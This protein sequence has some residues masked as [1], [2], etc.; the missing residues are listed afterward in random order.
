M[1][2]CPKCKR[3][4]RTLPDEEQDHPCPA[5]GWE[6]GDRDDEDDELEEGE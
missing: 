5:C 6:P 2:K 1:P 4:F 3:Y